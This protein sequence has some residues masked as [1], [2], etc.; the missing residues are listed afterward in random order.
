MSPRDHQIRRNEI[1]ATRLNHAGDYEVY[2][3]L[4]EATEQMRLDGEEIK[5]LSFMIAYGLSEQDLANDISH[6]PNCNG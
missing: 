5:R 2:H 4:I 3:A 6:L 1:L